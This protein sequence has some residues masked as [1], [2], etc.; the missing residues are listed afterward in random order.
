MLRVS[1]AALGVLGLVAVGIVA[2]GLVQQHLTLAQ[3]G[4]R[5]GSVLAVLLVAD[6]VV[7]P[8]GRALVGAPARRGRA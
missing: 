3:A 4:L 5:G 8:L 1:S 7:L 2:L 6:R